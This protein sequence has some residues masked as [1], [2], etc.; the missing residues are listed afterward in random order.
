MQ[1]LVGRDDE[2]T[3]FG[4]ALDRAAAGEGSAVVLRGEAGIGKTALIDDLAR[5][6]KGFRVLRARGHESELELPFAGL[7]ALLA[8]LL[9]G[10]EH[11]PAPQ[12]YALRGALALE[13]AQAVDLFAVA[14]GAFA[15]F[16]LA[17][18]T[19]PLL[20]LADDAQWL[21]TAT[22][23]VLTFAA[24]RIADVAGLV[25]FGAREGEPWPRGLDGVAAVQLSG[26]ADDAAIELLARDTAHPVARPVAAELAQRSAG[27]PLALL[28]LQGILDSE[29]RAGEKPLDDPLPVGHA[30]ETLFLR[31]ATALS[32]KTRR[33]LLRA[34]AEVE[35]LPED[36]PALEPA[37]RAGL[38]TVRHGRCEFR[39]PLVRS[40][41]YYGAT[42]PD[43]RRA[44]AEIASA[45]TGRDRPRRALHLALAAPAPDEAVAA[46]LEAS[47]AA[48]LAR[49]GVAEAA[50]FNELAANLSPDPA[51][52]TNR[53]AAAARATLFAGDLERAQSLA[54]EAARLSHL[55]SARARWPIIRSPLSSYGT[56]TQWRR[57]R[58]LVQAGGRVAHLDR[59]LASTLYAYAVY[60]AFTAAQ[61]RASVIAA[62]RAAELAEGAGG[63]VEQQARALL[64]SALVLAGEAGRRDEAL[65]RVAHLV[66]QEALMDALAVG[67]A[68]ALIWLES[69]DDARRMLAEGI[70]R[71][72]A[73]AAT[74]ALPMLLAG[75]CELDTWAGDLRGALSAGFEGVG[76]CEELGGQVGWPY[77]LSVLARVDAM[78]GLED[79]GRAHA[80]QALA[81]AEKMGLDSILAYAG[82]SLALLDLSL[83]R[84]DEVVERLE[85][86]R[87]FY[88][89][90]EIGELNSVPWHGDLAEAALANGKAAVVDGALEDLDSAVDRTGSRW[91]T[92]VAMRIRAMR[93]DELADADFL[94]AADLLAP[95]PFEVARTKLAHGERL[96]RAR[97]R[98]DSRAVLREA[99][100]AFERLGA[101]PWA[102]RARRELAAAGEA[103][104][105]PGAPLE[106]LLSPQEFQI[107]LL[108]AD[109]VTNRE[110]AMR[111]IVSPKTIEYH[112]ANAYRKLGVRSRVELVKRVSSR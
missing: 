33:A 94:A 64:G 21:D 72:R 77:A 40:A 26:L 90:R 22:A 80:Q 92:G 106:R 1:A 46:E 78:M 12:A 82:G 65:E 107:V 45:L 43:R 25:V 29:T 112:L 100:T 66:P 6:A 101:R 49:G 19:T 63:F 76:I 93:S 9:A 48:A 36:L 96:R 61:I 67:H 14:A 27:N 69:Y 110:A 38:V 32:A 31:R 8:P 56:A 44:H 84:F 103:V 51:A 2:R 28:E 89:E 7:A 109:G 42:E 70:A 99:L 59:V 81:I 102:D 20:V 91:A 79:A 54:V 24:R 50:R 5:R 3:L 4:E 52:R 41:I 108:A 53:L 34:T 74:T 85:P 23:D 58:T 111:L 87:A 95:M 57:T 47:A 75:L 13:A 73:A 71:A 68:L 11:L 15:L 30:I 104:T 18:D 97:R 16:A 17:A 83:G 88:A 86:L 35:V 105:P 60:P 39:H 10:L 37:E 62:A 98:A 55:T